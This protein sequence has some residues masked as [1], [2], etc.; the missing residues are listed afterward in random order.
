MRSGSGWVAAPF[1]FAALPYLL[2]SSPSVCLQ[3][4]ELEEWLFPGGST[5]AGP[6]EGGAA[7]HIANLVLQASM[8]AVQRA[9]P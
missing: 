5:T 4:A 3:V 8:L 2:W 6:D 7:Q 1:T 9:K